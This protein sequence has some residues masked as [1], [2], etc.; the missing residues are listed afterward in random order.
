MTLPGQPATLSELRRR[1]VIRV[2]GTH[3]PAPVA[4]RT[5]K[6]ATTRCTDASADARRWELTLGA[7]IVLLGAA[8]LIASRVPRLRATHGL[9]AIRALSLALALLGAATIVR[10]FGSA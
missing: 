9:I 2:F 3:T 7:T 4:N 5:P 6:L 8:A 1:P 10:S